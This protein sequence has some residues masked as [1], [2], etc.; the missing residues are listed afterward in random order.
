MVVHE[1]FAICSG[2]VKRQRFNDSGCPSM[3]GMRKE[4]E[5]WKTLTTLIDAKTQQN[6]CWWSWL[7]TF[8]TCRFAQPRTRLSMSANWWE[9]DLK[10][11]KTTFEKPFSQKHFAVHPSSSSS[12]PFFLKNITHWISTSW[13]PETPAFVS[14]RR[15]AS[16]GPLWTLHGSRPGFQSVT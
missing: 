11:A 1:V 8:S 9:A 6:H 12:N 14:N 3:T 4:L 15:V 7:H 5:S 10:V 2:L 13:V 16:W